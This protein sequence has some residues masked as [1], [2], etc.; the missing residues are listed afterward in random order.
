MQ[1]SNYKSQTHIGMLTSLY[2]LHNSYSMQLKVLS[3]KRQTKIIQKQKSSQKKSELQNTKIINHHENSLSHTE[4]Q[5]QIQ[6]GLCH[7][8][9]LSDI[10]RKTFN[11]YGK[12]K[13]Y[14]V[15]TLGTSRG[16]SMSFPESEMV[17]MRLM[18]QR[19]TAELFSIQF[20]DF[21][22]W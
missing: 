7:S 17:Q 12:L 21:L 15:L 20:C 9:S 6:P 18:H 2:V 4:L 11:F 14:L 8:G 1:D 19:C 5:K 16:L 22:V 10:I 3:R 13:F